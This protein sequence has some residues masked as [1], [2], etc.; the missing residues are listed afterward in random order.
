MYPP[1]N[2][3]TDTPQQQPT[4][5]E[6][7]GVYFTS[8]YGKKEARNPLRLIGSGIHKF[9]GSPLRASLT[10]ILLSAALAGAVFATNPQALRNAQ[11]AIIWIFS[12]GRIQ[13]NF[14]LPDAQFIESNSQS[15]TG[16]EN[17]SGNSV[18]GNN[19]SSNGGSNGGS[20]SSGGASND[21]G[22][23]FDF[24]NIGPKPTTPP[25]VVPAPP[26]SPSLKPIVSGAGFT[27]P[28]VFVS[29][30]QLNF[31]KQRVAQGQAP[32]STIY[33]Q[34]AS[35]AESIRTP[36]FTAMVKADNPT[37]KCSL[38]HPAGCIV[39]C[40]YD[41]KPNNG[42]KDELVDAASAYTQ[43]LLWYYTGQ[44]SYAQSA[45]TILNAYAKQ[46][47]GHT[48]QNRAIQLA[49][50]AQSM[51]RAAEIIRYSY[52]PSPGNPSFDVGR[53]SAMLNDVFTPVLT[54]YDY[55]SYNGNWDLSAIEGLINVAVFTDDRGLFNSAIDRWRERTPT[56]AYVSSD[57][58]R[59]AGAAGTRYANNT[60]ELAC[61][62]LSFKGSACATTP[63]S[64]PNSSYQHGQ[65]QETCRDFGHTGMG[66]A[67]MV[68]AAETAYLQ[69][70]NLYGEQGSRIMAAFTYATQHTY[71]YS[72]TGSYPKG[73][74]NDVGP[75]KPAT[76]SLVASEVAYNA[77]AVRGGSAFRPM[78]IPNMQNWA[79]PHNDPL[80]THIEATR[81]TTNGSGMISIWE[82]LTHHKVGRGIP[83]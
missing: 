76:S 55:R 48:G 71:N 49:W 74:C 57:G 82:T 3:H 36:V 20:S 44:E 39:E 30:E 6:P 5:P 77:Y 24:G 9:A 53:F 19:G 62:W 11:T 29:L 79:Y 75:L 70:V 73:F 66:L 45:V 56:Y 46:L 14:E 63:R 25:P 31:T 64:N 32:W 51:V 23:P 4:P 21:E 27:H 72:R 1:E 8:E 22:N 41:S 28:G 2:N 26:A 16:L 38:D 54:R 81:S 60:T 37:Q 78:N 52:T 43:A 40:G 47:K 17:G 59:P 42:C 61:L 10:I 65:A 18:P 83:F 67:S 7:Q 13:A 12:F 68:N 34:A 69:G 80:L 15:Y 33:R 35:S 50:A 58:A